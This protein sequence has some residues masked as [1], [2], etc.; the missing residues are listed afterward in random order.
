MP[1]TR[2]RSSKAILQDYLKKSLIQV[3]EPDCGP[4][5]GNQSGEKILVDGFNTGMVSIL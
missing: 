3:E 1:V 4:G 5:L 2:A